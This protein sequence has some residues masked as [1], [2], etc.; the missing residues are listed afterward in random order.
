M[1]AGL[2]LHTPAF[3][4]QVQFIRDPSLWLKSSDPYKWLYYRQWEL[5][6]WQDWLRRAE[7]EFPKGSYRINSCKWEIEELRDRINALEYQLNHPI[8]IG[9]LMRSVRDGRSP[10]VPKDP[11]INEVE[12]KRTDRLNQEVEKAKSELL[13]M[14]KS[15]LVIEK[16]DSP[17]PATLETEFQVLLNEHAIA[18]MVERL[19]SETKF[20]GIGPIPKLPIQPLAQ[21]RTP[22]ELREAIVREISRSK[23]ITNPAGIQVTVEAGGIVTLRGDVKDAKEAKMI[24]IMVRVTPGVRSVKRRTEVDFLLYG[25][26]TPSIHPPIEVRDLR[27]GDPRGCRI[28]HPVHRSEVNHAGAELVVHLVH[29]A[30]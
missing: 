22:A 14:Q 5:A 20:L 10:E 28:L 27:E 9:M 26:L 17:R 8:P 1:I 29:R 13:K 11:E 19:N 24:E 2:N 30:R 3:S 7:K 23:F 21:P 25:S 6:K 12:N 18:G 15:L 16:N 4:K